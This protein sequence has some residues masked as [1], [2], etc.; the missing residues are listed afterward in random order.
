MQVASEESV[1]GRF[2]A[3][4]VTTAG[5]ISRFFRDDGQF[6]VSTGR[7]GAEPEQFEVRYTFGVE[8]LQQYLIPLADGRLQ[9]FGLAWDTR[10]AAAGGQ[11]WFHLYPG[12]SLLA[13][14]RLHWTGID[15]NW[16]FQCA[17]CHSTNIRKNYDAATRSFDTTW[18][19]ISVGCEACH[20]PG[21]NH[22]AWATKT[23]GWRALEDTRGLTVALDERR[24]VVWTPQPTGTAQRS[25]PRAGEHEIE[26]CAR[27]HAR[28][29]QLSDAIQA[30]DE[31]LVAFRP[32]LLEPPNYYPDG[33]QREEVYT[34][35]SFVQSRMHAAGVTCADCHEPHS[36]ELRAPGN[37]VCAQCHVATAF[38][39]PGHHHHAPSS[40]GAACVSCHMP[41]TTYMI[42]DPRHDHSLR[43][44]RPDRT[45]ALGTPNACSACHSDRDAQWAAAAVDGWYPERKPG[46]QEFAEV[47]AAADRGDP[48]AA[49]GLAALMRDAQQ[50][51]LV[52]ASAVARGGRL[53]TP[54]LVT[55]IAA[56]VRDSAALV[57]ATAA[58]ALARVADPAARANLLEPLLADPVRLVRMSAARALVGAPQARL[59]ADGRARLAAA[60]AEWVAGEQFNA[61][62]PEAQANLGVLRGALGELDAA[63]AHFREALALEPKFAPATVNLAE[64]ERARGN[65]AGAEDLLRAA[66]ARDPAAAVIHH[67]LGLSLVRQ[68]ERDEAVAALGTAHELAPDDA[69]FAYVYA[70]ALHD[71]G[72]RDAAIDTLTRAAERHPYDRRFRQALADYGAEAR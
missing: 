12:E 50:P 25:T 1:L 29:S 2:D 38:D 5:D 13:G 70:V 24:G 48:A 63:A 16:N 6:R 68:G 10:E 22:V 42:V 19:E 72:Q 43:I 46:F 60:L 49:E 66:L 34:W 15:Q 30:G 71:T 53:G 14:D 4:A 54:N 23:T 44:P 51:A 7:A 56:A 39:T 52:R 67:A 58:D 18:S 36:Q 57:R 69:L 64:L 31:W 26:T 17:D 33:Q 62:R 35:G 8:P 65:E 37:A 59:S 41:T 9:A 28:R 3:E 11:R 47:F 32:A 61:D 45:V 27:C 40:P 55:P 21:S 20:G